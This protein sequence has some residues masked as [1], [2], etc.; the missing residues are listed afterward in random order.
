L[1]SVPS[2][3]P[4]PVNRFCATYCPY[5]TLSF[6]LHYSKF[7][8][9][10]MSTTCGDIQ[11]KNR[12]AIFFGVETSMKM[13]FHSFVQNRSQTR[14]PREPLSITPLLFFHYENVFGENRKT[15]SI[16]TNPNRII[17]HSELHS[18]SHAN[19]SRREFERRE[20]GGP[21][22]SEIQTG[23]AEIAVS[24]AFEYTAHRRKCG[25]EMHRRPAIRPNPFSNV[26]FPLP[27][28]CPACFQPPLTNPWN[29]QQ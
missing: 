14:E 4:D 2:N 19:R 7:T 5:C 24:T 17:S 29:C 25:P 12:H 1:E 15:I 23:I 22:K 9:D 18:V 8:I 6:T 20:S 27:L 11:Q 16:H 3:H 28:P 21:G 13:T 26:R 10:V